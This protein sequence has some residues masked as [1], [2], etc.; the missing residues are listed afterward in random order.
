MQNSVGPVIATA[1]ARADSLESLLAT[2]KSLTKQLR[3]VK[4]ELAGLES[5]KSEVSEKLLLGRTEQNNA[6]YGLAESYESRDKVKDLHRRLK[7]SVNELSE[8]TVQIKEELNVLDEYR[9]LKESEEEMQA[10]AK[11]ATEKF[12]EGSTEIRRVGAE[13]REV[14]DSI[15]KAKEKREQLLNSKSPDEQELSELEEKIETLREKRDELKELSSRTRKQM[16]K[17]EKN[18]GQ[19]RMGIIRIKKRKKEFISDFAIPED[20]P[21]EDKEKLAGLQS[22]RDA[23]ESEIKKLNDRINAE[24]EKDDSYQQLSEKVDVAYKSDRELKEKID[25]L[26]KKSGKIST[27][28]YVLNRKIK[29]VENRNRK[30]SSAESKEISEAK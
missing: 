27:R 26:R 14:N 25:E 5:E 30:D 12:K 29:S 23:L 17:V 1:Y 16:S 3:A 22:R 13:L 10:S 7:N 24:L 19:S 9:A 8:L 28:I 20:M 21:K 6:A 2:R 11:R 4:S 15:E 18:M